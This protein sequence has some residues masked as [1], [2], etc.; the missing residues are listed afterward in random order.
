MVQYDFRKDKGSFKPLWQNLS[1]ATG[2][3]SPGNHPSTHAQDDPSA[4]VAPSVRL[5][6]DPRR[7][8]RFS[9]TA[10]LAATPRNRRAGT[11][12]SDN[13]GGRRHSAIPATLRRQVSPYLGF[14]P[15]PSSPGIRSG[16]DA[17]RHAVCGDHA[18]PS[19]RMPGGAREQLTFLPEPVAGGGYQPKQGR[20]IVFGQ[21]TGA[22][23]F[24]STTALS[25]D[26][27]RRCC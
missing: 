9:A 13:F 27:R 23:S 3:A 18:A 21:D 1:P 24:S 15:P 6:N 16:G 25:P 11:D 10:L 7:M 14:A 26:I 4:S 5:R 22:G 2:A 20:Y 17:H 19:G 12:G 8:S